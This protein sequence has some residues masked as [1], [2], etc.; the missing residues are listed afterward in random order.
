MREKEKQQLVAEVNILREL[1]HPNI[2]RYYDRIIDKPNTRL[3]IVME[4]CEG[5][6]M[7]ALI[8]RCRRERDFIAEDVIW[9]VFMQV[10]VALQACHRRESSKI[11]HRDIK[12]GNLFLDKSMNVKLGDFGLSKIMGEESL[13]AYTH[14]G[15]PY[16]MS[17]EQINETKYNEKSDIWSTG[18]LMYEIASL[19]PPF[20]ARN[21]V[22]LAN[23]I[24]AGNV[25]RIP[26]RYS[27]ELQKVISWMLTVDHKKRPT[28]DDLLEIPFVSLRMREKN[29][30]DS[31]TE[32]KRREEKLK[33]RHS[34][35]LETKAALEKREKELTEREERL[36]KEQERQKK[37]K[38]EQQK[39]LE[40]YNFPKKEQTLKDYRRELTRQRSFEERENAKLSKNKSFDE[41]VSE[42]LQRVKRDDSMLKK[43]EKVAN[44]GRLNRVSPQA[45]SPRR[46]MTSLSPRR[47][48]YESPR[49]S[50]RVPHTF[51][52]IWKW[53]GQNG[54]R[55]QKDPSP[56]SRP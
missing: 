5:G 17:P 36:E 56:S 37:L 3:Y 50:P 38:E 55:R 33:E 10:L 12:P 54:Q 45:A 46:P 11:L 27:E 43:F 31:H 24:K 39:R 23:K 34:K 15:T 53:Y 40:E 2:V 47:R 4:F 7:G 44:K 32:F 14:V 49:H 20:Q 26:E 1:R 48:T 51:E 28:V 21:H 35:A 16:Y 9:K 41:L 22:E 8:K 42:G 19:Y 6:D 29:L 13:Y 25:S 18:C 52:N 30:R